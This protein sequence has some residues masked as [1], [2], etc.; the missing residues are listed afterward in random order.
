MRFFR[1]AGELQSQLHWLKCQIQFPVAKHPVSHC[2]VDAKGPFCLSP[3]V[4]ACQACFIWRPQRQVCACNTYV[5]QFKNVHVRASV[6]IYTY[7]CVPLIFHMCMPAHAQTLYAFPGAV[8]RHFQM[9]SERIAF[10]F[11][12]PQSL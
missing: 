10:C 6:C 2:H 12:T 3:S 5:Y 9:L 7:N 8:T 4:Y 11:Q 1:K